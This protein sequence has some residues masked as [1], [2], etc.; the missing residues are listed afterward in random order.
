LIMFDSFQSYQEW[1]KR[2]YGKLPSEKCTK[3]FYNMYKFTA[4]FP[5]DETFWRDPEKPLPKFIF[6]VEGEV[7]H[8]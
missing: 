1:Y 8:G 5:V 6:V 2:E 3:D 4:I 7:K